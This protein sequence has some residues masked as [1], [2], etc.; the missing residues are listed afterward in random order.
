MVPQALIKYGLHQGHDAL[1]YSGNI[2]TYKTVLMDR[3]M[4]KC[5][6]SCETMLKVQTVESVSPTLYTTTLRSAIN[7]N[8]FYCDKRDK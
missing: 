2:R 3:P 4:K 6:C 8:A 1:G 5:Q 7:I